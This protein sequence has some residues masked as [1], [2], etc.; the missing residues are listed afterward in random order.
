VGGEVVGV[1]LSG[2]TSSSAKAQLTK[3]GEERVF[4]GMLLVVEG[5]E[6]ILARVE[7]LR[8]VN[9]FF[10]EGDPW[11]EV[12][13]AWSEEVPSLREVARR[14]VVA[15]LSLIGVLGRGGVRDVRRPP[16]PGDRVV[17]LDLSQ[18]VEQVFGVRRGT[19]GVVWYGSLLGYSNAPIP[20]TVENITMHIGVFGETGSGKSYGVGYLIELLS[21]IPVGGGYAALPIIVIDANGDY[22]DYH[23]HFVESGEL[24][25]FRRVLRLVFPISRALNEPHTREL[26]IGLDEFTPRELAEI[27]VGYRY[28]GF[29][30]NELQVSALE[31]VLRELSDELP[32]SFTELLTGRID[33]V[34]ARL[35]ELSTG[36][37]API[38][39]QT[40]RAVRAALEKFEQDLVKNY[41]VVSKDPTLSTGLVDRVTSEP[42]LVLIDFSPEGAPGVPLTVK[43]L[44]IGYLT[45]I[46]YKRFTEYKVR[47]D[48]RYLLLVIEEAQ[49]YAPN[50]RNYPLGWSIAR[51]YL[52]LIATQGRKFGLSLCLVSQRPAFID[53]VVLSMLN[54]W[55]IHRV[56]PEDVP[57]IARASGGL[58]QGLE[59]R[60]TSLPRGVA[61]VAGQMNILGVPLLVEVGRRSVSH[62]MGR[63]RVVEA[64]RKLYG[65]R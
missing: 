57:Y 17:M 8:P 45:R 59:K 5:R 46:L 23:R 41:R 37:G 51:D 39:Y 18:G 21:R 15:E 61:V 6:K 49:N 14:Y 27:I 24:G 65:Y 33:L 10:V 22:L 2:A 58:P 62:E 56:A 40:A 48:V 30:L 11:S 34:Y 29:E 35:D 43:Q 53:P 55:I 36:R 31:R 19:P 28:G 63:T 3:R 54:T 9:E 47:G 44:V 1:I 4:E 16:E 60:L 50:P 13:R 52:A 12:R 20:L 32:Y 7:A 26:S 42:H 38:H 25:A 64:L